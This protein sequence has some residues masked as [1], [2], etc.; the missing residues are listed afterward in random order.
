MKW[1]IWKG[2]SAFVP[3]MDTVFFDREKEEFSSLAKESEI[4]EAYLGGWDLDPRLVKKCFQEER[5]CQC[6]KI[7]KGVKSLTCS[8]CRSLKGVRGRRLN[9][10]ALKGALM[11]HVCPD[12]GKTRWKTKEKGRAYECRGCGYLKIEEQ[13][14][15]REENDS[16]SH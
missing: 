3:D 14:I 2:D 9:G 5:K 1:I 4:P 16:E 12:C 13:E 10:L 15:R 6:G 7:F 8:N 11:C